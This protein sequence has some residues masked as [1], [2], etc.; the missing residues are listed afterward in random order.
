MSYI[1]FLSLPAYDANNELLATMR[2]IFFYTQVR[3]EKIVKYS[4]LVGQTF[5]SPFILVEAYMDYNI[6]LILLYFQY[7]KLKIDPLHW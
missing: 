6:R 1:H 3:G 4:F 7:I 2:I 5:S